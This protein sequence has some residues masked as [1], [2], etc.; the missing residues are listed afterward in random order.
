MQGDDPADHLDLF[1]AS[2]LSIRRHVK[3]RAEATAF[4]PAFQDYF[5]LRGPKDRLQHRIVE[6]VKVVEC[7]RP[8][9]EPPGQRPVMLRQVVE[10]ASG[11]ATV[12]GGEDFG[13]GFRPGC[14]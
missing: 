14:A 10:D 5:R 8:A 3:V 6:L 4:D 11:D 9:T 7:D 12:A 2:S 13:H 1:R